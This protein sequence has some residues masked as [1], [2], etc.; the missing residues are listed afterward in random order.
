MAG[1]W[2]S[3]SSNPTQTLGPARPQTPSQARK[4]MCLSQAMLCGGHCPL[5]LGAGG[6][7]STGFSVHMTGA[8]PPIS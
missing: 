1:G 3:N 2:A 6:A 8:P 7:D 4:Y 5:K